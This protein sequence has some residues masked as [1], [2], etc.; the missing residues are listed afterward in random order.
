MAVGYSIKIILNFVD[1]AEMALAL[2]LSNTS[3]TSAHCTL[4]T[5][6]VFQHNLIMVFYVVTREPKDPKEL[7][8]NEPV[9]NMQ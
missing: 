7:E 9:T 2:N 4:S 8:T 5:S 6:Q 3:S 1:L